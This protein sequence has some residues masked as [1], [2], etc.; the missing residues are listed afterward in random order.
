MLLGQTL[1]MRKHR[2]RTGRIDQ[3]HFEQ[4]ID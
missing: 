4:H 1:R 2:L 3:G